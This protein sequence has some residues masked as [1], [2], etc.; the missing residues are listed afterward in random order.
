MRHEALLMSL[1]CHR[2][3]VRWG[4]SFLK[5]FPAMAKQPAEQIA[6]AA[7]EA[8]TQSGE[9]AE[10]IVKGNAETMTQSGNASRA[11][12]QELTGRIKN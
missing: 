8:L 2:F 1:S 7:S 5:D 4:T 9:A 11:A 6:E 12:I 10:K 3:W